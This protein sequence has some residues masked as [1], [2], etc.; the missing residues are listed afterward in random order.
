MEHNTP[1][2]EDDNTESTG[3]Q[4]GAT[5]NN[6]ENAMNTKSV[7]RLSEITTMSSDLTH[8]DPGEHFQPINTDGLIK[9]EELIIED[10]TQN[11][12]NKENTMKNAPFTNCHVLVIDSDTKLPR[13][14][15][16]NV[17]KFHKFVLV[18]GGK[19]VH[20]DVVNANNMV[21]W[22]RME[23]PFCKTHVDQL[24][25]GKTLSIQSIKRDIVE[26]T[27]ALAPKVEKEV[28]TMTTKPKDRKTHIHTNGV[29]C[30]KC[31]MLHPTVQDVRNCY[32]ERYTFKST[33]FSNGVKCGHCK[34]YHPTAAD[35]KACYNNKG[36]K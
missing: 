8:V 26:E 22:Y 20:E 4:F 6:K 18:N 34:K 19:A 14:C 13:P 15:K 16:S 11:T 32:K 36:G 35:V 12:N 27:K 29:Y 24:L 21:G 31:K 33:E 25:Q 10:S 3:N 5:H 1:T 30:G 23:L 28:K 9:G 7:K 2:P 17:G